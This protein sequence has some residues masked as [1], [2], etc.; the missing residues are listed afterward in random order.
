LE[1]RRQ[2][3]VAGAVADRRFPAHLPRA[4]VRRVCEL[5]RDRTGYQRRQQHPGRSASQPRRGSRQRRHPPAAERRSPDEPRRTSSASTPAP[6]HASGEE[7]GGP[8]PATRRKLSLASSGIPPGPG[9]GAGAGA[10]GTRAIVFGRRRILAAHQRVVRRQPQ[11]ILRRR[12][13]RK[14]GLRRCCTSTARFR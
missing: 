9:P 4:D 11:T 2:G 13:L 12:L 1:P 6:G 3:T 10:R 7:A 5:L 8:Q 14:L